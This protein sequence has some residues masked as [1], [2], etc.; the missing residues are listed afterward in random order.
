MITVV[1]LAFLA[2][3]VTV[4]ITDWRRGVLMLVVTGALQDPARKLTP[5]TP[6]LMT[7]SVVLIYVAILVT[8]QFQLQRALADFTKR[9]SAVWSAFGIT[10]FFIILAAVNGLM[11]NGVALWK[12]PVASLFIY[13][14]PLPAVLIGYLYMDRED[15]LFTFIRVYCIVTSFA[16]VGT[17]LEYLRFDSRALGMV[18]QSGDYIRFL[19]GLQVR[20]LSGFY[21]GPDIMAWHAATLTSLA[22][23]MVVRAG[24]S[25][26]AG[27]WSLAA[28]WGCFNTIVSGRRKAIYMVAIFTAVFVWRYF[29]R[30]KTQQVAAFVVAALS[31]AFVVHEIA[32]NDNS[33]VYTKAA[34]TTEQELA[35]RLEGGLLGTIQQS[36]YL[37]QGLGVA[38]QGTYHFATDDQVSQGVFGWQ[39]GGL[40]KLT[41]ELGVPGLLAAALLMWRAL[42]M[43]NRIARHPDVPETSQIVRVM[44]FAAIVANIG[45]F[46]ASAQVYS[47]P[48]LTLLTAFMA[49]ALFGT[50]RLDE[51]DAASPAPAPPPVAK[52]QPVLA[53]VGD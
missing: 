16:L 27:L 29:R 14:A 37:G 44:L 46:L 30:L 9:F 25:R 15:R 13:L 11:T 42:L 53:V 12:V 4:A 36:G 3:A 17:V 23:V 49:G 43:M 39:E 19:P 41:V 48:V 32:S 1:F 10:M 28:V 35:E 50:S 6:F 22:I 38:T 21:R 26:S 31:I 24:I 33:S 7:M 20:M 47:D 51:A 8:M 40:G 34:S 52:P 45:N 5:G 18:A 2:L